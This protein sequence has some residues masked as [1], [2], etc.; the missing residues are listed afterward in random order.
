MCFRRIFVTFILCFIIPVSGCSDFFHLNKNI[1][2]TEDNYQLV[3]KT[4]NHD[5]AYYS[6]GSWHRKFWYGINLGA[7]I[8]GHHPG[9]LAP[10]YDDY[11]RWFS[12]MEKLGIDLVRVYTIMPPYF[13]KALVDH[14]QQAAG[15]L[16][17]VQG[18]WSP[19]EELIN[20]QNAYLPSITN[21]FHREISLAVKAVLG[22][23]E[24]PPEPGKASGNYTINAAPYLLAWM[25]GTEWHPYTV[26]QTNNL[27]PEKTRFSGEFFRTTAESS[28]FEAWLAHCLEVLAVEEAK[29]GWQHPVS[30]VNWVTTD[31]LSHPDEPFKKEDLVSVDPLHITPVKAWSAGYFTAYHAYPYYP[32][33]LRY[34]EDY[35]E[36]KNSRGMKEPYEA[37]LL[38]LKHHHAELPLVVAEFGVPSSRGMAHRGPL[39]RNQG[40]H[41]E[42][43]QGKMAVDMFQAI[44]RAGASGGIL[45]EWHDEWFKYTWNTWDLEIPPER[46]PMWL[47][48]L[49]NEENFGLI[50]VEP[51]YWTAVFLDGNLNDWS[52][53]KSSIK[54]IKHNKTG[55]Y[56]THDEAYLYLA[57]ELPQNWQWNNNKLYLGFS[58]QPGGNQ[59]IQ[60]T[61][62]KFSRGLEFLLTVDS[63]QK[64][65]LMVTSAYDQ[66]T[67]LYG[68]ALEMITWKDR[69]GQENNGIF[70]PWKLCLSRELILPASNR[71]I[72]FEEIEL[73]N[74]IPGI[75]D[76]GDP[77]YNS[78][79]DYYCRNNIIEL[80]I[81][82]MMLGFTDPS[83]HRVWAYPYREDLRYFTGTNSPGIDIE[84]ILT[85]KNEFNDPISVTY[86]W[87][88]WNIPTYHERKKQSFFY[89]QSF[90]SSRPDQNEIN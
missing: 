11:R 83:T 40:L 74:L 70:L 69:W 62:I 57:I 78:L 30:F 6:D 42:L 64:A 32:D 75:S 15:K 60:G 89:L 51:G 4:D 65:R 86:D 24:I 9:E 68:K 73:G 34:Q 61:G 90:L 33:S 23:V 36:Y 76:P 27:N 48:R 88:N 67:Y 5:I 22:Q 77:E 80:R 7:T 84:C 3:S 12:D 85:D 82:W 18:I 26:E 13:Y 19:E 50:A 45:F 39:N 2:K 54:T 49:T 29:A 87:N 20:K 10:S 14:N 47:N 8:P 63:P 17:F 59:F 72:P 81:P 53:I 46:R 16:W 28:P 38:E 52:K 21:K 58:T 79:A 56:I 71:Y 31:P 35:Q 66:H 25:L 55:I 1:Y 37:Y 41:T 43:E 44:K